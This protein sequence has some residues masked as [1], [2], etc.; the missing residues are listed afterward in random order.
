MLCICLSSRRPE[1]KRSKPTDHA[2]A[3]QPDPAPSQCPDPRSPR[4]GGDARGCS[5]PLSGCRSCAASSPHSS[6][7]G[8][9]PWGIC[10]SSLWFIGESPPRAVTALI[11][12]LRRND[13]EIAGLGISESQ[14]S[15]FCRKRR[16]RG[17]ALMVKAAWHGATR[18]RLA[19]GSPARHGK[20][21]SPGVGSATPPGWFLHR[22]PQLV[23]CTQPSSQDKSFL[24]LRAQGVPVG[25]SWTFFFHRMAPD[26]ARDEG[27]RGMLWL[28]PASRSEPGE[29]ARPLPAPQRQCAERFG[30]GGTLS[31][32]QPSQLCQ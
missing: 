18:G 12:V 14:R 25:S 29:G 11:G 21:Q 9:F 5:V 8:F 15:D 27:G 26:P 24:G 1:A 10:S 16:Q 7:G 17:R 28:C 23:F 4:L 30:G 20:V 6:A 31:R 22:H 13:A 19:A 2:T 32:P 3:G